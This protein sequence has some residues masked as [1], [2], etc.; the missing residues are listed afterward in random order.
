M[1]QV[2]DLLQK[3]NHYLEKFLLISEAELINF[4]AGDFDNLEAFYD[5]RE[6]ILNIVTHI[7]RELENT[8]AQ[9]EGERIADGVKDVIVQAMNRKDEIVARILDLDLK[10]IA[11]IESEKSEIIRE[12]RE[13][14][15]GRKVLDGYKAPQP[16]DHVLNEEI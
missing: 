16:A 9:F 12:L 13:L 10:L 14:S 8:S 11:C 2:I 5:C 4:E 7:E 15:K 6:K 1:D 3:K